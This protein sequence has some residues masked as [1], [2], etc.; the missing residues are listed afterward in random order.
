MNAAKG[1]FVTLPQLTM[2]EDGRYHPEELNGRQSA[3]T[4]ARAYNLT[5]WRHKRNEILRLCP[6]ANPGD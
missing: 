4:F 3:W 6:G 1:I 2:A 5:M